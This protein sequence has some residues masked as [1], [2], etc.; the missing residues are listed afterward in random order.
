MAE[1]RGKCIL[2][3]DDQPPVCTSLQFVFEA[4][5]YRVLTAQSGN[6]AIELAREHHF[7]ASLVDIHMP[8]MNGFEVCRKLRASRI[9]RGKSCAFWM[10]TGAPRAELKFMAEQVG[11]FGVFTKPFDTDALLDAVERAVALMHRRSFGN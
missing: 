10:M 6:D 11:A 9:G 4:A 2:I 1:S 3:V 8:E 5:G 7:D